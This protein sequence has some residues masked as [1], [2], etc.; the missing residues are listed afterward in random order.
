MGPPL[1]RL[2]GGH[3]C[4]GSM[5]PNEMSYDPNRHHRRSIRL[6][7]YDYAQPGAYFV[8][9]CV[10]QRACL[11]GEIADREMVRNEAGDMVE[12]WWNKLPQKF[13]TCETDAFVIMPNHVHGIIVMNEAVEADL[14]IGPDRRGAHSRTA[15]PRIV[16]WFKTMITNAYIRGVNEGEW[17]PFHGRLWQRSYYEHIVRSDDD[18]DRVREYTISNPLNWDDDP[19]NPATS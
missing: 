16:Q 9:L 3:P 18:L 4:I 10:Q 13:P 5:M 15:L 2:H 8:T 1:Q 11:F 12:S 19:D 6:P 17:T 14:R 7:G